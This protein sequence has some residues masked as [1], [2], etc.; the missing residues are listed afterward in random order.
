M[1]ILTGHAGVEFG[2]PRRRSRSGR[3]PIDL[4]LPDKARGGCEL[5]QR[6]EATEGEPKRS[7]LDLERMADKNRHDNS[8]P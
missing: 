6:E 7:R 3:P 5:R 2:L 4:P 8:P 1:S